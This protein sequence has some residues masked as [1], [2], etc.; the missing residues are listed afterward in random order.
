MNYEALKSELATPAYEKMTDQEAAD[1]LNAK[2]VAT[3]R[4]IP[5]REIATWAAENGLMATLYAAERDSNTPAALYGAIKTLLTILTPG[6]L[7]EWRVLDSSG[8]PTGAAQAMIGGLQQAGLM[9][10]ERATELLAMAQTAL[11]W[12]DVVG[13]GTVQPGHVQMI[14]EGR[15]A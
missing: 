1:A 14:R 7:D 11:R 15:W 10:D 5:T 2:T 13:I 12:V 6:L 9:T 3:V 4:N 8:A